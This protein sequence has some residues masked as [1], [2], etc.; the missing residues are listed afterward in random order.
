MK[1]INN[2][3]VVVGALMMLFLPVACSDILDEQPRNIYEPGYFKTEKG[4]QGGLTSMYAHLR[5]IFGQGYYYNI[6][7]TGTDEM[8]WANSADSNFKDA[9][10]TSG[11]TM[12]PSTSRSDVLWNEAFPNINTANGVIENAEE[13]GLNPALIAEARFFRAFDYFWL[14]QTFGGVPLDLGAGNLKFNTAPTRVSTR[15]TVP[16]VNTI[17]IFPDLKQAVQEIGRAHV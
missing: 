4:V 1:K 9:D 11:G 5:Y 14:V 10:M 3:K 7:L 6:T 12:T 16:E 8:T 17:G 2:I 13:V 15:N